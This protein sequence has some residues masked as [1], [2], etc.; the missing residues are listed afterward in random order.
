MFIPRWT[1]AIY[2]ILVAIVATGLVYRNVVAAWIIA[3]VTAGGAYGALVGIVDVYGAQSPL[4]KRLQNFLI[5]FIP[6]P[7]FLVYSQEA[8]ITFYLGLS[9]VL[10]GVGLRSLV[11]E[12]GTVD[13]SD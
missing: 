13:E 4:R 3:S 9:L 8:L 7:I 11:V 6:V 5:I 2:G 10:F 12:D 1:I